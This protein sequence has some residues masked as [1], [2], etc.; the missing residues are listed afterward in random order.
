MHYCSLYRNTGGIP[1]YCHKTAQLALRK[2]LLIDRSTI[3][4]KDSPPC[5][6]NRTNFL[7]GPQESGNI[8]MAAVSPPWGGGSANNVPFVFKPGNTNRA[9]TPGRESDI[10]R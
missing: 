7:G 4:I 5:C 8:M 1:K 2:L 6:N 9:Y 3:L 10:N